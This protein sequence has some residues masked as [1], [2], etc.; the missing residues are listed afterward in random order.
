LGGLYEA[1]HIS[2]APDR[3]AEFFV[4]GWLVFHSYGNSRGFEAARKDLGW[5][6]Q[7]AMMAHVRSLSG[8]RLGYQGIK[9]VEAMSLLVQER[10]NS[11][12]NADKG[13]SFV[14]DPSGAWRSEHMVDAFVA[15]VFPPESAKSAAKKLLDP[16]TMMFVLCMQQATASFAGT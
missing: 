7:K 2:A 15:L 14:A 9:T 16:L 10:L 11:A 12:F 3:T 6:Y 1:A 8:S 4:A 13:A 5:V